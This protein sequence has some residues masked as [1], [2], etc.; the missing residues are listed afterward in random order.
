MLMRLTGVALVL[1]AATIGWLI[2]GATIGMRT[3][4]SDV[5]QREQLAAIW[6]AEQAQQAPASCT[7]AVASTRKGTRSSTTRR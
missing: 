2:L 7:R 4:A 6:G 5:S 1:V 3:E